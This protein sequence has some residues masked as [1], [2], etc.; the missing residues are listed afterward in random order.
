MVGFV[1][2][3][4]LD[5]GLS[6]ATTNG[7]RIDITST[8]ATTYAQATTTYTLGN[9]T[10]VTTGSPAS[11]SPSG[12]KVTVASLTGGS[13]TGTGT[14]AYWALTDNSAILVATGGLSASQAVTSGNTFSLAAFDIGIPAVGGS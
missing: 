11:R 1:N 9:K 10:S 8:E 6:Y 4:V 2:T 7:T 14:A 13:V 5:S 3:S 12:R